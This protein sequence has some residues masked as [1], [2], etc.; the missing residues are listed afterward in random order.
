MKQQYEDELGGGGALP[1]WF[2]ELIQIAIAILLTLIEYF[3][4]IQYGSG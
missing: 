2:I 4:L 3:V 1:G